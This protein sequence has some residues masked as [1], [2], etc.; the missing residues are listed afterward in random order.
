MPHH[1][2]HPP[3]WIRNSSDGNGT[4]PA[5]RLRRAAG[6]TDDVRLG[7]MGTEIPEAEAAV[8]AAPPARWRPW[9]SG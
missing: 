8:T 6:P 9:V 3:A 1:T 2:K 5:T 7:P 4:K